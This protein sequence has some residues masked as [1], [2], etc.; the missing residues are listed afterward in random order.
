MNLEDFLAGRKVLTTTHSKVNGKIEVIN[1]FA[2]GTYIQVGGLTQ[3]GGVVE[4]VWSAS[5]KYIVG[6]PEFS[7]KNLLVIGL[8]GGSIPKL[9]KKYWPKIKITGVDIDPVMIELG[10]KYLSLDKYGVKAIVGDGEKVV[11]KEV[12]NKNKFDL[13]CIDTYV[14]SSYPKK[15][16]S[17]KFINNL[18]KIVSPK[19]YIIFNRLYY[20]EKKEIANKFEKL[21]VKNFSQVV[22]IYPQANVMFV[23]T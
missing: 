21:L 13:I 4:K 7:P 6:K 15:F 18:K 1:E 12:R 14:G 20:G 5:I 10:Q 9:A 11:Q 16:E 19:G 3:S 2:W 8:A 17:Q 22:R 23:C